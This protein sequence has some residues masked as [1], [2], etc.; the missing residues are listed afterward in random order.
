MKSFASVHAFWREF[1]TPNLTVVFFL[2]D[3]K[4]AVAFEQASCCQRSRRPARKSGGRRGTSKPSQRRHLCYWKE[5]SPKSEGQLFDDEG[6]SR[7][8]NH[9]CAQPFL[10]QHQRHLLPDDPRQSGPHSH[11]YRIHHSPTVAGA[12]FCMVGKCLPLV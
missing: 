3:Y 7:G 9:V 5:Q 8:G 1:Q 2:T 10:S 12:S 4:V 6:W 11:L